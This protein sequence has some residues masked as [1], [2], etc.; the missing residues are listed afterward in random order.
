M[1]D[2]TCYVDTAVA[3]DKGELKASSMDKVLRA[4]ILEAFMKADACLDQIIESNASPA[5][6]LAIEGVQRVYRS[7]GIVQGR[8]AS[9]FAVGNR[10]ADVK[11]EAKQGTVLGTSVKA[12]ILEVRWDGPSNESAQVSAEHVVRF[13]K[14]D[15]LTTG[16]IDVTTEGFVRHGDSSFTPAD[17]IVAHA[18]A[19]SKAKV[20]GSG[21]GMAIVVETS[22]GILCTSSLMTFDEA[23]CSNKKREMPS[24]EHEVIEKAKPNEESDEEIASLKCVIKEAVL[25]CEGDTSDI[26]KVSELISEQIVKT[27]ADRDWDRI[28]E[29]TLIS[30]AS[31]TQRSPVIGAVLGAVKGAASNYMT[32]PQKMAKIPFNRPIHSQVKTLGDLQVERGKKVDSSKVEEMLNRVQRAF[33]NARMVATTN[34]RSANLALARSFADMFRIAVSS[35]GEPWIPIKTSED[36]TMKEAFGTIDI[37]IKESF[38]DIDGDD[39]LIE[40]NKE[41]RLGQRAIFKLLNPMAIAMD[42]PSTDKK[43]AEAQMDVV[44]KMLVTYRQALQRL[45]AQPTSTALARRASKLLLS[46]MAHMTMNDSQPWAVVN[47]VGTTAPMSTDVPVK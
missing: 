38:S 40:Q 39:L 26:I 34:T 21:T 8:K 36:F 16:L 35:P 5:D 19:G 3:L 37:E 1:I 47:S 22:D 33:M 20:V 11:N 44:Q 42:K 32:A 15:S 24:K 2:S 30:F 7:F 18:V 25:A 43:A 45:L 31:Q 12:N 29:Q 23:S 46:L 41:F 28:V 27:S 17:P 9:D 6:I 4:D 13:G 14:S 10:V